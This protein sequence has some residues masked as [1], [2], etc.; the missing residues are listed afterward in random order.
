MSDVDVSAGTLYLVATPIGNLQD[1]SERARWIV[2]QV[3]RVLCEDTRETGRLLLRFG[4]HRP[5]VSFH[6]HNAR[7]RTKLA[8]QW[9]KA[10]QRLALVTDR[11]M[12]AISD[13]GQAL[14]DQVWKAGLTVRVIPGPSA[15]VTAYAASGFAA[16]FAFW[17]FLA[18]KGA[19][20]RKQL[21]EMVRWP[22][23][24]VIYE[25]PHRMSQTLADLVAVLGPDR[26]VLLAREMTKPFEEFWRG[27]IGQLAQ[28]S[29][30]LGECVLVIAPQAQQNARAVEVDWDLA[31]T[32][33][34]ELVKQGWTLSRA[35]KAVAEQHHV[36]RRTL[37]QK[38]HRSE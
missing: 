21:D 2:S 35:I 29:E 26:P 22:Y 25:A 33:V 36:S 14:V 13:P 11:G 8:L 7:A 32:R 27:P 34:V 18:R 31:Q 24:Q 37:Y 5:L 23:G 1:W 38:L 30:W 4:L 15:V 3:D 10:G 6:E 28:R 17:G 12:P 20:R 9:L 16:P 19:E